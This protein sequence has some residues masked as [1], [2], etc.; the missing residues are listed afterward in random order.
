VAQRRGAHGS[1]ALTIHPGA[2]GD[3]YI[4][5]EPGAIL[6]EPGSYKNGDAGTTHGS[7]YGYDRFVP[8]LVRDPNLGQ[9]GTIIEGKRYFTEFHDALVRMIENAPKH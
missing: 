1:Q 2:G 8:L 9:A 5:L 4:V 7:P 3:F 6:F